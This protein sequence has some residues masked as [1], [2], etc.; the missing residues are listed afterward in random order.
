MKTHLSTMLVIFAALGMTMQAQAH[1]YS[2][3]N[4]TDQTIAIG[5]KYKGDSEIQF[6]VMEPHEKG[7]FQPGTEG[8]SGVKS[9]IGYSKIDSIA[10]QW[11]YLVAPPLMTNKNKFTVPWKAFAFIYL[12]PDTYKVA[13]EAG[14]AIGTALETKAKTD[15]E[16]DTA[17]S[18]TTLAT[19]A[20]NE[21]VKTAAKKVA[22]GEALTAIVHTDYNLGAFISKVGNAVGPSME[23]SFHTDIIKDENGKIHFITI[24]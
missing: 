10:S 4:H 16:T 12:Q 22:K 2:F 9:G 20:T 19:D 7:E 14:V 3:S 24:L 11:Y 8:V 6:I 17:T 5:M 21:F 18:D 1:V 15:I 23:R 13:L